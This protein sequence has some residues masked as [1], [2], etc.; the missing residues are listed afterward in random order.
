MLLESPQ[1]LPLTLPERSGE[2]LEVV[3]MLRFCNEMFAFIQSLFPK[4]F[5]T[6]NSDKYKHPRQEVL[7]NSA[8]NTYIY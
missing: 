1:D 6:N 4:L 7:C 8:F 5:T 3:H 2:L